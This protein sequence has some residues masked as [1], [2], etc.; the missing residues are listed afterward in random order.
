M[1]NEWYDPLSLF[2][3][4]TVTEISSYLPRLFAALLI[5]VIGAAVA[6]ALKKLMVKGLEVL[7]VSK[8]VK[9]T[10]VEHFL[11][12]AEVGTKLE[13]VLGSVFYWLLMLVVIHTT[14]AVLG[15][16]SLSGVLERVLT[17]IPN[18]LSAVLVLFFGVLIAGVVES[19]IKGSIKSIDGKSSRLL[20]KVASYL[21]MTI[22]VMAAITE[23]GIAKEFIMI[24][25]V[26]FVT[27]LSLGTGLALGLGGQD[28][29][30]RMLN[31]WYE[32]TAKEVN[33]K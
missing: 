14:V 18:I 24:L 9:N 26:G 20:G 17:Y 25:F 33:K 27:M 8:A 13:E 32:R 5:L 11:Q 21:V 2:T 22:S 28:V 16:A 3:A 6:K 4:Q 23:L 30:R 29:V 15:L 1:P 19:L 31:G 12:N 10:P 7:M